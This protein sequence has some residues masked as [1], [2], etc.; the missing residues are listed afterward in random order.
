MVSLDTFIYLLRKVVY[1]N[2]TSGLYGRVNCCL[3]LRNRRSL[4]ENRVLK[5]TLEFQRNGMTG[6]WKKLQAS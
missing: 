5:R 2:F 3:T 6:E 1:Y 4:F